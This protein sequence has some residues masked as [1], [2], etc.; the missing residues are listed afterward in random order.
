M[1]NRAEVILNDDHYYVTTYKI[2]IIEPNGTQRIV[3]TVLGT[4]PKGPNF[5]EEDNARRQN[6]R[7]PV[8]VF[9]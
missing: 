7:I 8:T 9:K 2:E 6:N 1:L 5:D 3:T 4:V